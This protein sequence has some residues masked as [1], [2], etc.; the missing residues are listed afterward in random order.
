MLAVS[1]HG[2]SLRFPED[3]LK[4]NGILVFVEGFRKMLHLAAVNESITAQGCA[5]VYIDTIFRL[6]RL[7]RELVSDRAP[8]FAAEFWHSVFRSLGTRLKMSTSD[9]PETDDQTE[10]AKRVVEENLRG[11]VSSFSSWSE[12]LPMVELTINNSVHAS[13]QHTPFY[14]NGLRYP[15]VPALLECEYWINGGGTRSSKS[16]SGSCSLCVN[17]TVVTYDTDVDQVDIDEDEHLNNCDDTIIDSDDD[18]DAVIFI[19]VN[20]YPS[21]DDETLADEQE[22]EMSLSAAR[23]R[24]TERN[25][26]SSAEAFLLAIEA[27]VRFVQDSIAHAVDRQKRSADTHE[28]TNALSYFEGSSVLLSDKPL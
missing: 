4:N 18:D 23:T 14:V 1:L 27:V 24:R 10:R 3:D 28:S 20:D 13:T 22:E 16:L 2:L 9:H 21:E 15:R 5:C 19:I 17:D 6:H 25:N 11:Y 8:R 26:T 12:F 7:P